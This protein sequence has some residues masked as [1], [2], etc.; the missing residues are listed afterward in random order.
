MKE[1]R[2]RPRVTKKIGHFD[3]DRGEVGK[4]KADLPKKK[5][6]P[7]RKITLSDVAKMAY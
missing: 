4:R 7:R 1:Y 3:P 2:R 6:A 5:M